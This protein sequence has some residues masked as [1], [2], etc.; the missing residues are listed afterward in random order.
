[1]IR[2]IPN[3]NTNIQKHRKELKKC[4]IRQS[5]ETTKEIGEEPD[6]GDLVTIKKI[7]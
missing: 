1:M 4:I 2:I 6:P 3:I 5:K 7:Y